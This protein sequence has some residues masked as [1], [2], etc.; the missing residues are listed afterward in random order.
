MLT[1]IKVAHNL[2]DSSLKRIKVTFGT[3]MAMHK[4]KVLYCRSE[5]KAEFR[6][7]V[8]E[9]SDETILLNFFFFFSNVYEQT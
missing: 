4:H 3:R 6:I 2:K 7:I 9:I 5:E 8:S 1:A